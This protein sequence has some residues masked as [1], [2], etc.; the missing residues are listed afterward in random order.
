MDSTVI[1]F[2][3]F[4][5]SENDDGYFFDLIDQLNLDVV[6]PEGS[7]D[8]PTVGLEQPQGLNTSQG[9]QGALGVE[10][11]AGNTSTIS[12]ISAHDRHSTSNSAAQ[13]A[14]VNIPDV[15]PTFNLVGENQGI[16]IPMPPEPII[17]PLSYLRP[18]YGG[19][20]NGTN[21]GNPTV[22][23]PI[24]GGVYAPSTTRQAAFSN[25]HSENRSRRKRSRSS[26]PSARPET[27]RKRP[28][29]IRF[30]HDELSMPANFRANPDNHGRFQYT[31]TGRRRYLN[32]PE[33]VQERRRRREALVLIGGSLEGCEGLFHV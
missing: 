16:N 11:P 21:V 28:R 5:T 9:L 26:S 12:N 32:G 24:N 19:Y 14:N 13:G 15:P 29:P 17:V 31:A 25:T 8:I 30:V 20:I 27:T 18:V 7:S 23:Q 22:P 33:A 10:A 1:P 4:D 6:Q 2:I 3:A